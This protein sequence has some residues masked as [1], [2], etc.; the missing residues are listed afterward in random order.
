MLCVLEAG[1][2]TMKRCRLWDSCLQL[3]TSNKELLVVLSHYLMM[4]TSLPFVH[5]ARRSYRL[6]VPMK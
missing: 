3:Y 2:E 5:T 4:N 6:G 1:C